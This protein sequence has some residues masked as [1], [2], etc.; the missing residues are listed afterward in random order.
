M[1]QLFPTCFSVCFV[2]SVWI[3]HFLDEINFVAIHL[4]SQWPAPLVFIQTRA[5]LLALLIGLLGYSPHIE[6]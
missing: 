3:P 6:S 2:S 5:L 4:V 1:L